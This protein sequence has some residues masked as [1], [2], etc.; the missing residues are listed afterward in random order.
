MSHDQPAPTHDRKALIVEDD[1]MIAR[2]IADTL[3]D[4]GY[5][6]RHTA[7]AQDAL[8]V[9]NDWVPDVILLDLMLSGMDGW[10]FRRAQRTMGGPPSEVP[11]VIVSA[12]RA[13]EERMRELNAAAELL[14]PFDLDDLLRT[15]DEVCTERGRRPTP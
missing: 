6:A 5:Y 15:I 12:T 4:E 9:L 13:S 2:I 10:D 1:P 7:R 11:V 14:K 3:S 8:D